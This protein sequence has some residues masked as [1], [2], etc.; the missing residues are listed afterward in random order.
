MCKYGILL[1]SLFTTIHGNEQQTSIFKVVK[2]LHVPAL[3]L[4]SDIAKPTIISEQDKKKLTLQINLLTADQIIPMAYDLCA[5]HLQAGNYSRTETDSTFLSKMEL[6]AGGEHKNDSLLN[7]IDHTKTSFGKALLAL[8]LAQPIYDANLLT[9]RQE[10]VKTLIND[11]DLLQKIEK[12]LTIMAEAEPYLFSY[13]EQEN[14]VNEELFKKVYFGEWFNYLNTSAI[15]LEGWTRLGNAGSLF[16]ATFFPNYG[17]LLAAG[18]DYTI[19]YGKYAEDQHYNKI[20]GA[21][22]PA[23]VPQP[24]LGE[25]YVKTI[26]KLPSFIRNLDPRKK[27]FKEIPYDEIHNNHPQTLGDFLHIADYEASQNPEAA[28]AFKRAKITIAGFSAFIIASQAFL[29]Y[30]AVK[31]ELLKRD[32]ANYLQTKMIAVASYLNAAKTLYDLAQT[33]PILATIP[34]LH[35]IEALFN[36]HAL[37]SSD[38]KSLI[39]L[40]DHNTFIGEASIAS[41][42]GR[43]LAAHQL[44][45]KVKNELIPACAAAS[46]F[47]VYFSTA[48]LYKK[49]ENQR[50]H[51]TFANYIVDAQAPYV[52]L[53]TFWNPGVAANIVVA[54]D[55]IFGVEQPNNIILTGPNTG[56]KSTVIKSALINLLLAQTIGIAPC[57]EITFTLFAVLNCYL[58]I[59]DDLSAG[60]SLFKA[61][62]LRAKALIEAIRG[63]QLGQF[64]FTIMDEVFSGTSPKEGEEAAYMFAKELGIMQ[65]S[66]CTIATHFPK[67][68]ELEDMKKFKNYQVKVWK[69]ENNNWV[70]PFKLEAG[71]STLNIAMD[72]LEEAGIFSHA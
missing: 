32:I 51:Y 12:Q 42:T 17:M 18:A 25:S 66:I 59:T 22:H 19:A 72:L 50:V 41:L 62:V 33:N 68:T 64:S 3:N 28:K 39:R 10:L 55:I 21:Q 53:K 45:K 35:H 47:D 14:S 34:G 23:T 5:E 70:R 38:L 26:K 48:Q 58:N 9:L 36:P 60:V 20:Y 49:F 16:F 46:T 43:V 1:L 13:F 6:F 8:Q 65:N 67:L 69:D 56:G 29:T 57:D 40:L 7:K 15:A 2:E 24:A 31:N 30:T 71:R 61:E 52:N 44:M 4:P 63:L 37:H 27:A 11:Q 54:N